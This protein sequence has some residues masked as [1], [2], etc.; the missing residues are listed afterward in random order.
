MAE[1][2]Q[3]RDVQLEFAFDRLLPAKLEQI[4]VMLVP[5]L[6]RV[7]RAGADVTGGRD[8]DRRDL[9]SGVVGQTEGGKHDR[10]PDSGADRIRQ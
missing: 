2:Q 3:K 1:R 5:D 6:A 4:Y 8:E 7:V 10:Q 9:R